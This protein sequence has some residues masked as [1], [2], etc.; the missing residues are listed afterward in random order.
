MTP[1]EPEIALVFSP[2]PWVEELHRHFT[3][4]GGVRVRQLVVDPALALDEIYD[5]LVAASS[6]PALTHGL[7][8]ALHERRHRVLGVFERDDPGAREHLESIGVDRCIESDAGPAAFEAV[9]VA[10]APRDVPA[11]A[12][13]DT[14]V[15]ASSDG[16]RSDRVVVGGPG[17]TG[18]TEMAIH[19]AAGLAGGSSD[20]SQDVA[21]LDADDVMPSIGQ[22]L[23][24]PI[25]PNLRTA[26]D[27]VQHGMGDLDACLVPVGGSSVRVCAGL[28][29]AAAW[30]QLRP[31]EVLDVLERLERSGHRVVTDVGHM[32]EDLGSGGRTR[33]SLARAVV[34][35]AD[36]LVGVASGTPVGVARILG[37][38]ADV[39]HLNPHA[40]VHLVVNR[41]PREPFKRSE[42][43]REI[44]RT[45]R[46][47]GLTF[48]PADRRVEAAAWSGAIV[49][50]GPFSRAVGRLVRELP[51]S[52]RSDVAT[53]ETGDLVGPGAYR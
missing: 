21:L 52:D 8:D 12:V 42:I 43:E 2:E 35:E 13:P 1:R 30:S 19:L 28:P 27:A 48:L 6:W 34:A 17:G 29:N 39:R 47:A 32:L 20:G 51:A 3:D 31:H 7:V 23:A 11:E 53:V 33:Y 46:P 9:L 10:L 37:W 38:V 45:H 44:V 41:A 25:E 4:H 14:P 15:R 22:R 50:R 5:T 18:A 26:V 16:S 49:E 24:L 40:P 36:R